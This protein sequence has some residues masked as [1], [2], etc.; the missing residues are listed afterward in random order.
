MENGF[1]NMRSSIYKSI[2]LW[3]HKFVNIFSIINKNLKREPTAASIAATSTSVPPP[4]PCTSATADFTMI[5]NANLG[6]TSTGVL[7]QHA[8]E[9][10]Q[11]AGGVPGQ[12]I[13]HN[14]GNNMADLLR[15]R[16]SLKTVLIQP[17]EADIR[18]I[19]KIK[20]PSSGLI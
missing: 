2:N 19:A 12:P 16:N 4:N 18:N 5:S 11:Q 1:I 9:Q 10:R 8:P 13:V 20:P 14:M 7:R 3:I 15:I 6:S 17:K